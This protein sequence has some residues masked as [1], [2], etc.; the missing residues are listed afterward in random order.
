MGPYDPS[1]LVEHSVQESDFLLNGLGVRY[2]SIS[3]E[4]SSNKGHSTVRLI[5]HGGKGGTREIRH[6]RQKQR[7]CKIKM[8]GLV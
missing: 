7:S 1:L 4:K 5:L 3:Y 2:E 6:E 8:F